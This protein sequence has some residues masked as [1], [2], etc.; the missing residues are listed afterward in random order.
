M[1]CSAKTYDGASRIFSSLST[2]LEFAASESSD[3]VV[4]EGAE[5]FTL[6]R[7]NGE[8]VL[9]DITKKLDYKK[10]YWGD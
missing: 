9:T 10:D 5:S 3:V 7:K 8:W 1:T 4:T 2:A 6:K